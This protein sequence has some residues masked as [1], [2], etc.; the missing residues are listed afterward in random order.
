[1]FILSPQDVQISTIQHPK[2]NQAVSILSYQG[3]SFRLISVFSAQQE[4]EAKACWRELTD[5]KGKTCVLLAEAA[6]YSVWG[7][8]R[9]NN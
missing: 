2:R 1:M 3:Q 9:L 6:R 5:N 4:A 8:V 7:K